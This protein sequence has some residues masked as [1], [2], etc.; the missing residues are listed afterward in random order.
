MRNWAPTDRMNRSDDGALIQA[1]DLRKDYYIGEV[2][3]PAV[4]GASLTIQRGEFVAIM[5]PSGS[6][7]STFMHLLGCLDKP[8]GGTYYLDGVEVSRLDDDELAEIRNRKIGFVFQTYNLLPRMTALENVMLP[9]VYAGLP[10][11]ERY[12]RAQYY[13]ERVGLADRMHHYPTQ[14]SGGEQQRVA[15]ARAL[16]NDPILILGDEPTGNLDTR[17]G[18]EI[19]SLFQDLHREGRTIVLVTHEPD[20]ARHCERIVRFRDG[21]VVGDEKVTEP[22]DARTILA[23]L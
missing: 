2:V 9:M 15:I 12:R 23:T 16:C 10:K 14:L 22:L 5:G 20:I 3:I 13:L 4:R 19:M 1:I 17:T 6:G 11:R 7:K 8:T 18:E 21:K